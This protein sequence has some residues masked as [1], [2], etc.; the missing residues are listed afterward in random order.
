MEKQEDPHCCS[1]KYMPLSEK[2]GGTYTCPMH[3]EVIKDSPGTCPKCGMALEQKEI[4]ESVS[5]TTLYTCPMHPEIVQDKPGSCP[6]CGMVLELKEAAQEQEKNPEL[7]SM[8]KRFWV[9]LALSSKA[10][11]H[12]GQ[13]PGLS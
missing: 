4:K 12:F 11:P 8:S 6:K 1:R 5:A 7:Q 9:C 10:M 13:P 3:S 2:A